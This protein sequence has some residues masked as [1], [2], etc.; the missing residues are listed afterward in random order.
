[1]GFL[2]AFAILFL[3][4]ILPVGVWVRYDEDGFVLKLLAGPARIGLIP[5]S[6]KKNKKKKPKKASSKTGTGKTGATDP[7]KE[8][9]TGP[10]TDF[11][12]LIQIAFD[13][14]GDFFH[15][16]RFDSFQLDVTFG[17]DDPCDLAIN[18]G[19]T[20]AIVSALEPALSQILDIKRKDLRLRVDFEASQTVVFLCAQVTMSLGALLVLLVR[21]GFL[22]A[23]EYFN[24]IKLRKGGASL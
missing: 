24:I 16:L 13:L 17:G 19:K 6:Q 18:Y 22:A 8:K 21:Y 4:A 9:T 2:I 20:Q 7:E 3:L 10:I 5:G 11:F 1:M 14:L 12:P 15:K 23:R